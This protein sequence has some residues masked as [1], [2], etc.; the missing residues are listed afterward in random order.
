MSHQWCPMILLGC[1]W[2]V[3]LIFRV[4]SADKSLNSTARP[5]R[6]RAK[7][8]KYYQDGKDL[9]RIAE[10][11]MV[12]APAIAAKLP[13]IN[14]YHAEACYLDQLP[15]LDRRQCP[16]EKPTAIHVVNMDSLNAALQLAAQYKW[17]SRVMVLNMANFE[18]PGGG[19]LKGAKAQ[20]ET[21]CYRSSLALSLDARF[22]PWP[23][24]MG[25]YTRDVV[26]MRHDMASGHGLMVGSSGS[27]EPQRLP[28]VSVMSVAAQRNPRVCQVKNQVLY[29]QDAMR[30]LTEAKMRLCLRT[31]ARKG[32]GLLVLGAL[33]CGV[34][35]HP[36]TEVA[37][38]W[39]RVLQEAEFAGGWWKAIWFAVL[40][41]RSSAKVPG[42]FSRELA[43]LEV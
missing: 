31:A 4:F 21:L 14:P 32:H 36:A 10:E 15:C 11:T 40:D 1:G 39:R 23:Q 24:L 34:F 19:W 35:G 6:R 41:G 29:Q 8:K 3:E 9:V 28:L 22:Y 38:C 42:V 27:I 16:R 43:G 18:R 20:E 37:Q 26:V 2:I 30:Q 7:S 33:G 12:M 25:L 17:E 13:N 5:G